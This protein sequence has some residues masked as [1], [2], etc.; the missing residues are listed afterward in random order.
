MDFGP[1]FEQGLRLMIEALGQAQASARAPLTPAQMVAELADL[2]ASRGRPAF[3]PYLGSGL[4]R[5][6][7]AMLADGRWVL[8]F[9]L[10]IGVH[11]FGHGNLDLIE[12]ALRAAASD[13]VMQGNLVFNREYGRL[14]KTILAHVPRGMEHCWLSLSG[15]DANENALKLI[16]QKR[17]GH[18]GIIAFRGCFHGRTSAMAEITD[19]PD[20]R[21]G[22]PRTFPVGYIPF[23]DRRD[24]DSPAKTLG[25]MREIIRRGSDRI[26]AFVVE[27]VQGEAGFVTAPREFFLPLFEEC[28]RAGIAIWIDEVQTFARVSELFATDLLGLADYADVITIGKVFQG[29]AMLYRKG[30]EPDPALISGTYSGATVPMAVAL[31]I[32]EKLTTEGFFGPEG[33]EKQLE[34]ATRDH[35]ER[36]SRKHPGVISRIDGV[37]AM[38]AFR[39]G[40]GALARMREFIRRCFDAGLVLYYGGHEPA[41]IRLFLPVVLTDEELAEAF[42]I[43]ERCL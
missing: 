34:R 16:R 27:L 3:Y 15:A 2:A 32:I 33:R 28:R 25:A 40:D 36:L 11:L 41:C 43:I 35:L 31:R 9:A 21:V 23:F 10:G 8:D 38:I 20:Y 19:R 37:G 18:P 14:M 12:T 4:G 6:A 5:G 7:R 26:A 39:I 30:F 42:A 24:P 22:Q 1:K 13:L 29:S 17:D